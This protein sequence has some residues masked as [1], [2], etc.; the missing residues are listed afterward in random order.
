MKR[1]S[2]IFTALSRRYNTMKG[3]RRELQ[4][5][6]GELTRLSKISIFAM[7]RGASAVTELR[8]AETIYAKGWRLIERNADLQ[9]VG[10]WHAGCEE[11][12][13]ALLVHAFVTKDQKAFRRVMK[14]AP[15]TAI[16]ALSD[17]VGELVRRSV[18][19]A[20]DGRVDAV[21][22]IVK[23]ADEIVSFLTSLDLTGPLR[24]KGDQARQH[25]RKI[26]DIRY[27]LSRRS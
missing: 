21:N 5:L 27:E 8:S 23:K 17:F 26:E 11:F 2:P 12:A 20:T 16:G 6:G 1:S 14:M 22:G 25:L 24:A 9:E 4:A 10:A 18:R 13:E 3:A 7:Q 19:E 15:D